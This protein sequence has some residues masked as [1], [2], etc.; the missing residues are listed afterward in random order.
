MRGRSGEI[1]HTTK[2][3][4][5]RAD[6]EGECL[7]QGNL[8]GNA[9]AMGAMEMEAPGKDQIAPGGQILT[10]REN[11]GGGGIRIMSTETESS[12]CLV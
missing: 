8:A 6:V 2:S 10:S 4:T 7:K 12:Q 1:P 11:E 5:K 9:R 3:V